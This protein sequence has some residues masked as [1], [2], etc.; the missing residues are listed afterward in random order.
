MKENRIGS[1]PVVDDNNYLVGI[2]TRVDIF[3]AFIDILGV[4]AVGT[5]I[6]IKTKDSIGIIADITN[7]IKNNNI[8][9]RNISNFNENGHLELIIKVRSLETDK[10]I[11]DLKAAGYEVISVTKQ[12]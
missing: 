9:I 4:K 8:D 12:Y 1:L 3:K 5:R 11:E 6:A 10:L 7:I 2:V